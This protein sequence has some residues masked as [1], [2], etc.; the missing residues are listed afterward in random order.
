MEDSKFIKFV[1]DNNELVGDTDGDNTGEVSIVTRDLDD[2][3][4]A[5][6]SVQLITNVVKHACESTELLFEGIVVDGEEAGNWRVLIERVDEPLED[7]P[8]FD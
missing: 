3:A 1:G 6:L 5:E 4:L 2:D 7:S 8:P